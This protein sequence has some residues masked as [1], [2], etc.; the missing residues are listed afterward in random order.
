MSAIAMRIL[1]IGPSGLVTNASLRRLASRGWG[2]RLTETLRE[3]R[4]LL[5]TFRFDLIFA[6]EA[7]PDGRG[8]D[9]APLAT[10]QSGTLMVGV[11]L[12]ESWLWLPVVDRGTNVLGKRALN[13]SVIEAE[14]EAILT[15]PRRANIIEI[16]SDTSS[17]PTQPKP[18]HADAPERASAAGRVA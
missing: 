15:L 16:I 3:A 1:A 14:A 11:A 18:Q 5:G 9:I 7:L 10:R 2:S 17:E 8:Y 12:S 4:E 13:S 6:A